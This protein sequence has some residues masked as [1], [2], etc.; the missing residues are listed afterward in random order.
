MYTVTK[1]TG[2]YAKSLSY[3]ELKTQLSDSIK[4]EE[5]A[6]ALQQLEFEKEVLADSI[7]RAEEQRVAQENIQIEKIHKIKNRNENI[8]LS[9]HVLTANQSQCL[10]SFL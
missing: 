5:T 6:K 7:S 3:L 10:Y 8:E 9:C 1:A 4:L 2:H